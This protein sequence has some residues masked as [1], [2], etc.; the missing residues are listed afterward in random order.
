MPGG[1]ICAAQNGILHGQ[2]VRVDHERPFAVLYNDS[3]HPAGIPWWL[4]LVPV[5]VPDVHSDPKPDGF[6]AR[7]AKLTH[8]AI[9]VDSHLDAPDQLD[10]NLQE[11]VR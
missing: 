1:S 8:D 4:L 9:V 5:L 11:V 2:P 3:C 7:G 6:A 10:E